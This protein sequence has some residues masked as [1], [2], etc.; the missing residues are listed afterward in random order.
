M[1]CNHP[2]K[3]FDTGCLTENGKSDYLVCPST[4][5]DIVGVGYAQKRGKHIGAGAPLK[6]INGHTVLCDPVPIPCGHC[7]GCRL[8]AAKEYTVRSVLESAFWKNSYFITLTVDDAHLTFTKENGE[9]VIC[10]RDLQLFFKRLRR[11]G[12]SFRYLACGEYGENSGRPHYHMIM[13][14]DYD[15]PLNLESVNVYSCPF[16]ESV[17]DL[18][19]VQVSYAEPNSMAYVSGY[20]MKK[21]KDPHWDD[22][23]Y[24]PFRLVSRKPALGLPAVLPDSVASTGKVYG[25]FGKIRHA[26]LPLIFKRHFDQQTKDVR[27]YLKDVSRELWSSRFCGIGSLNEDLL[28]FHLDEVKI[29]KLK[30][31][32]MDK[33]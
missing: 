18:G 10:K 4:A 31:I 29:N 17:W 33:L 13:F 25:A 30:D 5:G 7:V 19:L 16:L 21:V 6:R 3:A 12:L 2:L 32:R 11:L 15:L 14:T 9:A 27:E 22:Y 28:G 20:V 23:P 1:S 8:D 26:P 24:K